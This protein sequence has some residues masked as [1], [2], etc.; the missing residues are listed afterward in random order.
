MAADLP[1]PATLAEAWMLEVPLDVP[2]QCT[3]IA[4]QIAGLRNDIAQQQQQL[5][6][7]SASEKPAIIRAIIADYGKIGQ[8]EAEQRGDPRLPPPVVFVRHV[9]LYSSRN[10]VP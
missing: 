7:A 2:T 10:E 3:A 5:R 1:M 8:Y 9:S 6:Q 4:E